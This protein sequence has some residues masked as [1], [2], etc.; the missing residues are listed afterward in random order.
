MQHYTDYKYV[1]INDNILE[2]VK[3][4]LSIINFNLFIDNINL[5][6]NK[7]LNIIINK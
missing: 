7:K 6:V 4:L 3:N 2:T 5:N 1:L